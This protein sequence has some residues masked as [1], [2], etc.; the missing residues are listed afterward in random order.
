MEIEVKVGSL[1][2]VVSGH[3]VH[4]CNAQGVMGSGVALAVKQK[5]P[6]VFAN[7]ENCG[8]VLGC[9]YP[10]AV[11]ESL[12]VWNAITQESYGAGRQVSYDAIE[13]C[14]AG[15]NERVVSSK[16]GKAD[17]HIHIPLIG[18]DRG[19]GKWEIVRSII[20]NTVTVPVTL[21]KLE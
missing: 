18:C 19:G 11:T 4:G 20:E 10:V 21:W 17:R 15:I 5:W 2:D 8:M 3:I 1:L 6:N 7:Y 13:T 16:L 9:A 14:F 12:V